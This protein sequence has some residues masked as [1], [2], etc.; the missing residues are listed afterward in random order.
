[1]LTLNENGKTYT[2]HSDKYDYTL[3]DV[4]GFHEYDKVYECDY[5]VYSVHTSENHYYLKED[6]EVLFSFRT[7]VDSPE[8]CFLK[9]NYIIF[10]PLFTNE[11]FIFKN[12][13]EIKD[14]KVNNEKNKNI[15][16]FKK[17]YFTVSDGH[18]W[19]SEEK[20]G[21][22][23][24]PF[25]LIFEFKDGYGDRWCIITLIKKDKKSDEYY[26]LYEDN[27][28]GSDRKR[29]SIYDLNGNLI[30]EKRGSSSN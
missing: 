21:Y 25:D 5:N 16:Q 14:I 13:N 28:D 12:K 23:Y 22:Y 6:G 24:T 27:L 1:M 11:T 29:T 10:K 2:L 15:F 30:E 18:G 7:P 19:V 17:Y 3:Y 26:I 4:N 20:E 9:N 8:V